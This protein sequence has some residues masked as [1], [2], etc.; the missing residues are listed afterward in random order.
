MVVKEYRGQISLVGFVLACVFSWRGHD[1]I[2]NGDS[3]VLHTL[4][5]IYNFQHQAVLFVLSR[6]NGN[7]R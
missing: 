1:G 6:D 2:D 7:A 5:G 4:T 3:G